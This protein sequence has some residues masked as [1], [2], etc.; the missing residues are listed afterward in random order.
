MKTKPIPKS[1]RK[2]GPNTRESARKA[3]RRDPNFA[4]SKDIHEDRG[5]IQAHLAAL[6]APPSPKRK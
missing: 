4:Q 3:R 6:K 2:L 1:T 5:A